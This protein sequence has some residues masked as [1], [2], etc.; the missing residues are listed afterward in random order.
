M[1]EEEW[2]TVRVRSPGGMD[3][4]TSSGYNRTLT[5]IAAEATS[6]GS[7]QP[8]L[9][10]AVGRVSQAPAQ[11]RSYWQ[12]VAS[13]EQGPW[14]MNQPPV[15]GPTPMIIWAAQTGL[16]KTNTQKSDCRNVL[17]AF[18][19]LKLSS[20]SN[21]RMHSVQPAVCGSRLA[22]YSHQNEIQAQDQPVWAILPKGKPF[23][24]L[25]L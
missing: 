1:E 22:H 20:L 19:Y 10:L 18:V 7:N 3:K 24:T 6:T 5:L 11:L 15:D 2:E 16:F 25:V 13:E 9:Q 17:L 14:Q 4:L 21:R 8:A 12:L 23:V